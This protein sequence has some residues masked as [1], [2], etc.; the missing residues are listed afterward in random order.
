VKNKLPV[1]EIIA[2]F[3]LI[4]AIY[5]LGSLA[6]VQEIVRPNKDLDRVDKPEKGQWI[7]NYSKIILLSLLLSLITTAAAFFIF[8]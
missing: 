8:P 3:L 2:S 7:T 4:L 1:L 5:F 6:L